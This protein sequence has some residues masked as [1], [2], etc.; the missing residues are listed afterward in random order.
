IRSMSMWRC[1]AGRR[2]RKPTRSTSRPA[3]FLKIAPPVSP[4]RRRHDMPKKIDGE[5]VGYGRPPSPSRFKPGQSGNPRGRPKGQ[6]N[7]LSD[8][9]DELAEKIRIREGD[10]KSTRLNSSHT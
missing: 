3:K 4:K 6:R 9:R 8:L 5:G 10:R 2:T 7:L 1:D